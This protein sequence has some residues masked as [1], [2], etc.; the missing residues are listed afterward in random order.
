MTY[1]IQAIKD[2]LS[3]SDVMRRDGHEPRRMG[4]G[5]F[6]RCPF[7][8]EKSASCK[9]EEKKFHC[10][11]CGAGTDVFD[12]WSRSRGTTKRET[13]E[14]LAS[15]AGIAP[16]ID[17]YTKPLLPAA[18]RPK[19]EEIIAPL[20][21]AQR[22]DWF[23]CV[24]ELRRRPAEITR[25]A[26]WRG[27]DE[28][29][30]RWAIERGVIGL[31]KWSGVWREA[32][33][34][35]MPE[36]PAGPL[37]PVSTHIRLAPRSKSNEKSDK[38][39]WR[40]DPSGCGGWPLVFGEPATATHLFLLEGQ[41]DAL[42]LV[43]LMR[44]HVTW[45]AGLCLVAMRGATSFRKFLAS[46]TLH[47]KST[48]F[49]IADADNAGAEWFREDGLVHQLSARVRIVHAFWPGT[50]GLDL[51]DLVKSGLTRD[52]MLTILRP[53]L[54]SQRHRKPGGPTFL[55]WC[56]DRIKAPDPLGNAARLVVADD[57]RP[58]GRRRKAVWERHWRKLNL[59][60]ELTAAL[61]AAWDTYKS[62]CTP[63]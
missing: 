8:E 42:A 44:W 39:S 56:R 41:W 26:A 60:D 59:P 5:W 9:V 27:L 17:G 38:A 6:V 45:P 33:L 52:H 51:N 29:V 40:F 24:D 19:P 36:S 30:I 37:I 2:R 54:R 25:I 46:Y 14:Q 15:L 18:P 34:V 1:D 63:S 32:F 58:T 21:A 3:V 61:S 4:A 13:I 28:D 49:A 12:Y 48:A 7:H 35:E 55:A 47:E 23:A 31:K 62:E 16:H 10:F 50:R 11:G 22:A 20:T 57:T 43:H 53:K